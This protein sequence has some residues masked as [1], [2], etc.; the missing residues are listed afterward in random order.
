M[1]EGGRGKR[2]KGERKGRGSEEG[3]C[4]GWVR[5]EREKEN[6]IYVYQ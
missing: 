5:A 3:D 6:V 4:D 1:G 2:D